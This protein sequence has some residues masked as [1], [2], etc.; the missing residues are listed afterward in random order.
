MCGS[1]TNWASL[2]AAKSFAELCSHKL[3]VVSESAHIFRRAQGGRA[4]RATVARPEDKQY[5]W[6]LQ[7]SHFPCEPRRI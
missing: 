1:Y 7:V 2:A 3:L 4:K 6:D 5:V